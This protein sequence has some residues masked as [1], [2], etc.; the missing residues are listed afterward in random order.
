ANYENDSVLEE[1]LG[2]SIEFITP[3]A[4]Q[5]EQAFKLLM[6]SRKNLPDVV[7][8]NWLTAY[9]GGPER[10]IKSSII[11]DL[12]PY[13]SAHAPYYQEQ[14]A[15]DDERLKESKT[16]SGAIYGF[17]AISP[18]NQRILDGFM[19]RED[20]LREL[21]L[22]IPETIPEWEAVLIAFK[23]QKNC[24]Y[25]LSITLN[26]LINHMIPAYGMSQGFYLKE[27]KVQ[28]GAIRPEYKD[29]LVTMN[30]WYEAELIDPSFAAIDE[31]TVKSNL[32]RE[33]SGAT[34]GNWQIAKENELGLVAVPFPTL[35]KGQVLEVLPAS[36]GGRTGKRTAAITGRSS[37]IEVIM[38]WFDEQYKEQ[39]FEQAI[40]DREALEI[41]NQNIVDITSNGLPPIVA[42]PS[43]DKELGEL[44]GEIERYVMEKTIGF[45]MGVEPLDQFDEFV[46]QIKMM[47]IQR[48]ITI[49]QVAVDR[50]NNR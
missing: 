15:S 38:Q 45:I 20:W 39:E 42:T 2:I 43:E 40:L 50:Y 11:K 25:P 41:F 32:I 16:D 13:L 5:S 4:N 35:E 6:A 12:T 30:R 47:G 19:I 21:G 24:L 22:E 49:K 34:F 36:Y 23:T 10:A 48:A 17:H 44:L 18:S 14:I 7:E 3:E 9:P 46:T 28:Y 8:T 31:Q 27:G 26:E 1:A 33:K 29:F 37:H